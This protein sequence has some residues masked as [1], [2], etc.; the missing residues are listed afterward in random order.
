MVTTDGPAFVFRRA[1][2]AYQKGADVSWRREIMFFHKLRKGSVIRYFHIVTGS[3]RYLNLSTRRRQL[4]A[5]C[6]MVLSIYIN[7]RAS[8]SQV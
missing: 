6:N 5:P 7:W 3:D 4:L 1:P 8:P 2:K